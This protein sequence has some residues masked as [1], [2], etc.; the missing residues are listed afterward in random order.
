MYDNYMGIFEISIDVSMIYTRLY[1][2]L[3][4]QSQKS[5]SVF[6]QTYN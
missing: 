4:G 5:P 1:F 2:H 3:F 6:L